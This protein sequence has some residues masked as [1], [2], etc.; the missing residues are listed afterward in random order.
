[1]TVAAITMVKNEADVIEDTV[2][3]ML[4]EVGEAGIVI[5]ADNLSTDETRPILDRVAGE[6]GRLVVVDDPDPAYEQSAKMTHLARVAAERG[7]TIII[8]FD[9]DE[10][11]YSMAG[12]VGEVLQRLPDSP[13]A[14]A[15]TMFNH[16][17]TSVDPVEGTP[18]QRLRWRKVEPGAMPKVA[19]RYEPEAVIHMGNHGV[20][21]PSGIGMWP[22]APGLLEIRHFPVRSAEQFT[23]KGVQGGEALAQTGMPANIGAHW[24][25]YKTLHDRGTAEAGGDRAGGDRVLAAVYAEHFFYSAPW[26]SGMVE[27]PAPVRRWETTS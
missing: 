24:R 21:L 17:P 25:G 1:V 5:V 26:E 9:A 20:T 18:F 14:I 4:G 12:R 23:R 6:D 16:Y 3:H 10:V 8:P 22:S 2:R 19:F 27:D 15:A 7:A 13:W 11:W